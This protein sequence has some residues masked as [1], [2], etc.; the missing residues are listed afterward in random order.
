MINEEVQGHIDTAQGRR[1]EGRKLLGRDDV[2]AARRKFEEALDAIK[3]GLAMLDFEEPPDSADPTDED[4]DLAAIFADL[5]GIKGGI[6][7]D[8][9]VFDPKYREH[10]ISAYDAGAKYERTFALKSTYNFVNQLVMRFLDR[11]ELLMNRDRPLTIEA[12]G[13]GP[14]TDSV[15]NWLRRADEHVSDSLGRRDDPAWAL[16]DLV[17]L[18]ALQSSEEFAPRLDRFEQQVER[19]RDTYPYISLLPV[20][21]ELAH[22]TAPRT[23]EAVR[24]LESWLGKRVPHR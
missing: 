9:I 23:P 1:R 13:D 7:R 18:A 16:A 3:S 22:A 15:S 17:L 20:A 12:H 5:H 6:Y 24:E 8:M 11:P 10:A 4:R 14:D 2:T 19:D 21:R